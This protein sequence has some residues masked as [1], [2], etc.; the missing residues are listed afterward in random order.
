M[1]RPTFRLH[2]IALMQAVMNSQTLTEAARRMHVSQPAVSKQLKQ[3]QADMGFTLF[4]RKG[5]RLVPT[6]EARAMLEQVARVD[7]SLGVLN[8]MAGDFRNARHGH[9]QIGCIPSVGSHLL[10]RALLAAIGSP[11]GE[12]GVQCSV[13]TGSTAQVV[14][15]V[16]S[17]QVDVGICLRVKSVA[18]SPYVPLVPVRIECLLPPRHPLAALKGI[19]PEDLAGYPVIG[20]EVPPIS[21][22]TPLDPP[23]DDGLGSVLVRVDSAHAACRMA[24]AGMGIAVADS[25]TIAACIRKP[26]V[27]RPL[28][29]SY[30]G[31]IGL[32]RP[33]YRPRHGSVDD[34]IEA[35]R[36]LVPELEPMP[37]R[38]DALTQ[39]RIAT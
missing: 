8:R 23:W 27:R 2:H 17:Q 15:W 22:A 19:R 35:L 29:H 14:E 20:L 38:V 33:S 4:E 34:L 12:G 9:L 30:R 28:L 5:H 11:A 39:A 36:A 37:A 32:Y 26:M 13:H 31:E 7:A 25:L 1:I 24:E 16:E 3:L 18:N 10:P 21:N 6:F